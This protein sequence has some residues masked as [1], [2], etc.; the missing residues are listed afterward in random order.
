MLRLVGAVAG[1]LA[2]ALIVALYYVSSL[3]QQVRQQVQQVA[4]LCAT[5]NSIKADIENIGSQAVQ[6]SE[7]IRVLPDE[8][9]ID[10]GNCRAVVLASFSFLE[11][12]K[13]SAPD[14]YRYAKA[15]VEKKDET[16]EL[17]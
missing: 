13:G 12:W 11:K 9:A 17:T 6:F 3:R 2:V 7:F 15:L 10:A 4:T 16:K 14:T 8:K 5:V 1:I